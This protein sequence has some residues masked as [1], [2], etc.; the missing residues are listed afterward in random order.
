MCTLSDLPKKKPGPPHKASGP[1]KDGHKAIREETPGEELDAA[2]SAMHDMLS[3]CS[4]RVA[5]DLERVVA[6]LRPRAGRRCV[7]RPAPICTA[8]RGAAFHLR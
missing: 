6:A 5:D 1:G 3:R 2:W 4:E 7:M 8:S